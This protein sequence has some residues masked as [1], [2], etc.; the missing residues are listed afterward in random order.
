MSEQRLLVIGVGSELGSLATSLLERDERFTDI[1]GIDVHP[2][3]RRLRRTNF[4]RVEHDDHTTFVQRIIGHRPDVVVHLGVWEPHARLGTDDARVATGSYANALCEALTQLD[5]LSRLVI[6]SGL[7]VY[8]VTR[9]FNPD[10]SSPVMPTSTYG[11]MLA[12]IEATT[13]AAAP[14]TATVTTLRF[15]PVLGAHVPSPLG[16][17]LRLPIV[18]VDPLS[19]AKF[20]VLADD[21]AARAVVHAATHGHHGVVNVAASDATTIAAAARQG[22][23]LVAPVVPATWN[24]AAQLTT[25]AGAPLPDH[26]VELLRHGRTATSVVHDVGYRPTRSTHDVINHL[27]AWPSVI[28]IAPNRPLES[29]A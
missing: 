10:E 11:H 6:R 16:R 1:V 21:D 26:V 15:A 20:Q 13:K 9:G 3:R 8:G 5:G 29:V 4:A 12:E 24:I 18:P 7:E 27:F 14:S 17:L 23:R 22:G 25:L 19:R 2:P 28:R